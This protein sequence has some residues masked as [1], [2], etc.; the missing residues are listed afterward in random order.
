MALSNHILTIV[1]PSIELDQLKF[2]PYG[3]SKGENNTSQ[4]YGGQGYPFVMING[5]MFSPEDIQSFEI[6]VDGLIPRIS[7]TIVDSMGQFAI[8]TFPRDGDVINVR[9][10][11]KNQDIYRDIRIDF[12]ID[13]VQTP[14]L[15]SIQ[16]GVGGGKYTFTGTM[17]V[18]GLF[19]DI[20]SSYETATSKDHLI[21]IA[22]ELGLGLATNIETANDAMK[23]IVAYETRMDAIKDR[24]EHSY[25]GEES[26]Q[27][28]SIDP[29]Y[30]INYVDMNALLESEEDFEQALIENDINLLDKVNDTEGLNQQ[31]SFNILTSHNRA[32]GTAAHILAYSLKNQ[33]GKAVKANGYKRVLQYFENDSEERL[34]SFDVEALTSSQ[35]KDIEEPLRGRRDEERYK[36]EVKYK[37]MGRLDVDPETSN[38]HL[39]YNFSRVHNKQNMDELKKLTLEVELSGFNPS[40]H[41]Y[42]KIPVAIFNQVQNQVYA[43]LNLKNKKSEQNFETSDV[44][45]ESDGIAEPNTLDDFLS[46]FYI[47]GDIRYKYSKKLGRMTQSL[48]LLR[49]EWPSRFNN[50]G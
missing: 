42:Q 3:E 11:P 16:V 35:M 34:V 36:E 46:G 15:S 2:K 5:Y 7:V 47:I 17:K 29:Y 45:D 22:N 48:T 9:I 10:A 25:V 21:Q 32:E 1:E 38:T 13:S 50:I 14:L 40:L 37:Y 6:R 31:S 28:F 23:F 8:D 43:D 12:D 33:S 41:R 18:P 30:Y 27:T 19:A 24:V 26:F 44:N 4:D 39:N 20:C 49:R